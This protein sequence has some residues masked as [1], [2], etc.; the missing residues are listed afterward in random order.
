M[1]RG[2]AYGDQVM[3]K[4]LGEIE[5][6]LMLVII[7]A[8]AAGAQGQEPGI[9][10]QAVGEGFSSKRRRRAY[11][12]HHHYGLALYGRSYPYTYS[13]Y[14][15]GYRYQYS[16]RIY[17]TPSS[18]SYPYYAGYGTSRCPSSVYGTPPT[19]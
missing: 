4:T 15:S 7:A 14:S 1:F 16:G 10:K 3:H 19:R 17:R 12:Y 8:P 13:G 2:S 5:A 18:Y 11:E 9:Q 6:A